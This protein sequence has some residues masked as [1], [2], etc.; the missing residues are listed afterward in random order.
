VAKEDEILLCQCSP[1]GDCELEF[2]QT[3]PDLDADE[4]VPLVLDASLKSWTM[5]T[6]DV[7]SWELDLAQPLDYR[8]GQFVLLS[9]N[10]VPG[11][12]A[13][14][15]VNYE[16]GSTRIELL[17]KKKP[18]GGFSEEL[19]R[20]SP[21]GCTFQLIGP[22]GRSVF[23]PE[24]GKDLLCIAGGSGIAGM[25]SILSYADEIGYFS[26]RSGDIFFG[27]RT[28]KDAFF[29]DR[30]DRMALASS[31]LNIFVC[32]SDETVPSDSVCVEKYR[33]LHFAHGFV[34]EVAIK[35]MKGRLGNAHA[36]VAG[37][38]PAVDAAMR[39]LVIQGKL[40]PTHIS[41]DK[42]D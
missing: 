4:Y 28:M 41:C 18:G 35:E 25:M 37:P 15:I 42:F 12:R 7:A 2:K 36:F 13:Y 5:L 24:M 11:A 9:M 40:S 10:G 34:S 22:L 8:A 23:K 16:P 3:I 20:S 29:L 38:P 26:E 30:L 1:V 27:V 17:V 19:F 32:L 31:R 6:S 33:G 14:S 21:V 39:C